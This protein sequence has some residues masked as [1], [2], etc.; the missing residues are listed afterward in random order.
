MKMRLL[1]AAVAIALLPLAA[2]KP[3]PEVVTDT[4]PDPMATALKNAPAVELPPAIKAT[5]SMRC[6]PGNALVFAEFFQGDKLVKL[7]TEKNGKPTDLKAPEA[8]QP[9]TAE[10]GYKLTGN[11][12][13]AT[14]ELPGK[15]SLS[16]KG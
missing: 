3:E 13:S 4:A 15:G 9:F 7:R 11:E 2:C 6:Q 1:P 5:V 8:G 14:V 10:G 16:C 12:K